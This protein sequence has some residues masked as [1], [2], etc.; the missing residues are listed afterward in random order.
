MIR[1]FFRALAAVWRSLL[2]VGLAPAA[3]QTGQMF[4]ELVGKVTDD[5]GGVLPGVTVTLSGPGR[6]GRADARRP[7]R[8]AC[9]ASPPSTPAPT[10]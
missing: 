5:Q 8:A 7:T 10:S 4:G 1:A 6:D 9:T 2:V 3:A